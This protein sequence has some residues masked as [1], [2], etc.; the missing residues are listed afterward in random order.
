MTTFQRLWRALQKAHREPPADLTTAIRALPDVGQLPPPWA[1]WTLISLVGHRDQQQWFFSLVYNTPGGGAQNLPDSGLVPGVP[2]WEY[3]FHGI[4]CRVTHRVTGETL[5]F[6]FHEPTGDYI[7]V[8]SFIL[9][10]RSLRNPE[11]PEARLIALH[12]SYDPVRLAVLDLLEAGMLTPLAGPN[13]NPF[14]VAEVAL[15]HEGDIQ[16][17]C[18]K[19]ERPDLRIW[20]AALVGDWLA[21]HEL[22]IGEGD[23]GLIDLTAGRAAACLALRR[24]ALWA[25]GGDEDRRVA[26]LTATDDIDAQGRGDHLV[27]A[28]EGPIGGGTSQ[29]VLIIQERDD[30]AWCPAIYRLFCRLD[31]ARDTLEPRLRV[32][33]Q[34]FL[35]RHGH[36]GDELRGAL[37]EAGEFALG[38][39]AL[40]ALEYDLGRARHLLSR[41]LR[42]SIPMDRAQVAAA[43]A[44]FDRPWSRRELLAAIGESEDQVATAEC[45][46]ALLEC[47][48]EEARAAVRDWERA[49]PFEPEPGPWL[50]RGR[51]ALQYATDSIRYWMEQLHELVM[52]VRY[53]VPD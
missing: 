17:F 15:N 22:A 53:D 48:D 13:P 5:D 26:V 27:R 19:W 42:S 9:S 43:L 52:K 46:A 32:E 11:P 14:R 31:P 24:R 28:L 41:A 38:G 33:C 51:M 10:L 16:A 21:A 34:R 50:S 30:P 44:L 25:H 23:Q 49:N 3:C 6:D 40:L 8:Y 47:H 37:D 35:L 29:A 18:V 2:E 12:P 45:R 39:A 7:D 1:T 20:L 36:R 4:G